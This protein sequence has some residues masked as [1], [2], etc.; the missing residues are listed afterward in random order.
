MLENIQEVD[1]LFSLCFDLLILSALCQMYD[2]YYFYSNCL[3]SLNLVTEST[4][5][6]EGQLFG[7]R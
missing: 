3:F 7:K 2:S 4:T 5:K 6:N 1:N